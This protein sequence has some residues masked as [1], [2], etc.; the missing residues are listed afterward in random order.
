[1]T[2]LWSFSHPSPAAPVLASPSDIVAAA[3]DWPVSPVL[4]CGPHPVNVVVP[5][6]A[7]HPKAASYPV[8][9]PIGAMAG[10]MATAAE[11]AVKKGPLRCLAPG[12]SHQ[13]CLEA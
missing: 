6:V 13:L 5:A 1:M 2:A 11:A 7:P 9:P 10:A 4:P 3:Q 8:Q 12:P